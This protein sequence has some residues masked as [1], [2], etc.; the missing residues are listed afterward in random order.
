MRPMHA[1]RTYSGA[2]KEFSNYLTRIDPSRRKDL[3]KGAAEICII[4]LSTTVMQILNWFYRDYSF[5]TG[6]LM[7]RPQL[8]LL[9]WKRRPA[10]NLGPAFEQLPC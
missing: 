5:C 7:K 2:V 6:H 9:L 4:G 1:G 10:T 8:V 3:T